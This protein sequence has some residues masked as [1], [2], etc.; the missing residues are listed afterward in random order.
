M[1]SGCKDQGISSLSG[2][3]SAFGPSHL[4]FFGAKYLCINQALGVSYNLSK[5][6]WVPKEALTSKSV[7]FFKS[8]AFLKVKSNLLLTINSIISLEHI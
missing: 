4:Y 5:S 2:E 8:S 3:K 6:E 1:W 7:T